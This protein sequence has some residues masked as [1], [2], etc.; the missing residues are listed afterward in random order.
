MSGTLFVARKKEKTI[1]RKHLCER[2]VHEC[3]ITAP[4]ETQEH[5]RMP[6]TDI[7]QPSCNRGEVSTIIDYAKTEMRL[8]KLW[9]VYKRAYVPFS[10][11]IT[12]GLRFSAGGV[13]GRAPA[14]GE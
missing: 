5:C 7:M 11:K 14:P 1:N 3:S 9:G 8:N 6:A 13:T 4:D 12:V 10:F 2:Q